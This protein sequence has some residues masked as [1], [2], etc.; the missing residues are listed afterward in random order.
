MYQYIV[1]HHSGVRGGWSR[2]YNISC[3][4]CGEFLFY[5]QKDGSG[6][7]KRSYLD[8]IIHDKPL[9]DQSGYFHCSGCG[10]ILGFKD[11]YKKEQDRPIIRWAIDAISKK[12]VAASFL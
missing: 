9:F 1:D 10:F 12:I 7:L 4:Q 11:V 5:Y 2:V 3:K 6:E 8:R